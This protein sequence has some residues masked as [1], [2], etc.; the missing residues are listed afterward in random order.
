LFAALC[1][2]R[3]RWIIRYREHSFASTRADWDT[4]TNA[5]ANAG[6]NGGRSDKLA[7]FSCDE[8]RKLRSLWQTHAYARERQ[9]Y[10]LS[11]RRDR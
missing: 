9:S 7:K 5:D 3:W 2:R 1:V 4:D 8:G 11:F 6:G 10:F